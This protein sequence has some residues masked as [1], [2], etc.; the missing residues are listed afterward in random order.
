MMSELQAASETGRAAGARHVLVVDNDPSI[1]ELVTAILSDEGY[2]VTAI[3]E[4]DRVSVSEAVGRFEPDCILLDS[5]DG[6]D[7]A[8]S[9]RETA[10]LSRRGRSVP[11]VMFTA[12]S[13][14]VREAQDGSS[15]R[16]AE[17]N[18]AG[19]LPKPFR[20]DELLDVVAEAAGRSQPF[21]RSAEGERRR[22]E[23]LVEELER[24]GA[25]QI[26]TSTRREWATF[27]VPNDDGLYQLYW[28]QR[29]GRYIVG[30]YDEDAHLEILGRYLEL[31][32]AIGATLDR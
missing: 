32:E 7:F 24:H 23:R 10:Y 3:H 25:Q 12:G 6:P 16:A 15:P 13:D 2:E 14:A 4:G 1:T 21:D 28:W 30:R 29:L 8:G 19:I 5:A 11:T 22:T 17:A 31:D 9:W 27:V 26:A 20:L 18:F